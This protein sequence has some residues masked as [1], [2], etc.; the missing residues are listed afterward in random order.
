MVT[1]M[2]QDTI[3]GKILTIP[4]VTLIL[5]ILLQPSLPALN[6]IKEKRA[7]SLNK[8]AVEALEKKDFLQAIDLERPCLV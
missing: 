5:L 2:R 3:R 8:Q 1:G 7:S 6:I 4:V